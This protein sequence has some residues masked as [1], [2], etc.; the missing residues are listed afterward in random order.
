MHHSRSIDGNAADKQDRLGPGSWCTRP[1]RLIRETVSYARN[2][3]MNKPPAVKCQSV[4]IFTSWTRHQGKWRER[5][6][7]SSSTRLT[8]RDLMIWSETTST[9]FLGGLYCGFFV[10]LMRYVI[11]NFTACL[12]TIG[13]SAV[14]NS[15]SSN[16]SGSHKPL[17]NL[18]SIR[19]LHFLEICYWQF[20]S[21][22]RPLTEVLLIIREVLMLQVPTNHFPTWHHFCLKHTLF[23]LDYIT[24][25][26]DTCVNMQKC[27]D[28]QLSYVDTSD[29]TPHKY[30]IFIHST[31]LKSSQTFKQSAECCFC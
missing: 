30:T 29:T 15:W 21:M 1:L 18:T 6:D 4:S 17:S 24:K 27:T 8:K 3:T 14:T 31:L 10:S 5:M 2:Y 11:G 16:T 12:P 26:N 23:T 28:W 13:G 22:F 20:H 25:Q 7:D 9:F 19:F